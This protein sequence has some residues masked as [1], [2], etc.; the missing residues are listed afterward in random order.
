MTMIEIEVAPPPSHCAYFVYIS[1]ETVDVSEAAL[2]LPPHLPT[3]HLSFFLFVT[4]APSLLVYSCKFTNECE[5]KI[6][7]YAF[8]LVLYRF[9]S[10]VYCYL[11]FGWFS[12]VFRYKKT[13]WFSLNF[14]LIYRQR[15][16]TCCVT[17]WIAF[18]DFSFRFLF[19]FILLV[20]FIL[21]KSFV[22]RT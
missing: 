8:V 9:N 4:S 5:L 3:H 1:S 15:F 2:C 6:K 11:F 10:C 18:I 21:H 19:C 22:S 20:A 13:N 16:N 14:D 7:K 12:F 17:F